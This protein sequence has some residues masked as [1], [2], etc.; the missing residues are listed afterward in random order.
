MKTLLLCEFGV[1]CSYSLMEAFKNNPN[2]FHIWAYTNEIIE[3][4]GVSCL[5]G[6]VHC[7]Q[8]LESGKKGDYLNLDELLSLFVEELIQVY[9][10]KLWLL[11]NILKLIPVE[12]IITFNLFS[13]NRCLQTITKQNNH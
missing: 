1:I 3:N 5:F 13:V 10:N 4:C 9:K 11:T 12:A 2:Q 6:P 7:V 8:V